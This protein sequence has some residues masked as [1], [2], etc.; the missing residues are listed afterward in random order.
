MNIVIQYN[1]KHVIAFV[2]A[3]LLIIGGSLYWRSL[4]SSPPPDKTPA[5]STANTATPTPQANDG[6][7]VDVTR[8]PITS[9]E[10]TT[11]RVAF[12][13]HS[14]DLSTFDANT[15]VL[16]RAANGTIAAPT[17]VGGNRETHHRTIEVTFKTLAFPGTL[18]IN[19]LGSIPERIFEIE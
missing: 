14:G 3:I 1:Q 13:T 4:R 17:K 16:F 12:N 11:F 8:L 18:V 2:I 9:D 6:I 5:K 19:N 7:D 15:N 10:S